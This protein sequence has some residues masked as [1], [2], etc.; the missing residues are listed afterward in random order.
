VYAIDLMS[1]HAR[2]EE[3][4]FFDVP[5]ERRFD[6]LVQSMVINNVDP[7][8]KRGEMLLRCAA[9]LK[10]GGFMLIT[11]PRLCIEKSSFVSRKRWLA[12]VRGS[13]FE[14]VA[15]KDTPKVAFFVL[16]L[17]GGDDGDGGEDIDE[18]DDSD[19]NDGKVG[20]SG[21]IRGS[22]GGGARGARGASGSCGGSGGSSSTV[23]SPVEY[24]VQNS[25]GGSS[26][27][28]G[29]SGSGGGGSS[30]STGVGDDVEAAFAFASA[31]K[32]SE[33]AFQYPDPPPV[34]VKGR[35]MNNAF[36]VSFVPPQ[37]CNATEA[38]T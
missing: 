24:T 38:K 17:K 27:G 3:K 16:Q 37:Q 10:P 6:V 15:S 26:G 4:D 35:K 8:R 14:M 12:M 20:S 22:G 11:L 28:L 29:S 21:G 7:A 5:C 33:L 32:W 19:S 34:V 2:I 31:D 1:R 9:H 30:S 18:G 23:A 13:G 25:S 36:A